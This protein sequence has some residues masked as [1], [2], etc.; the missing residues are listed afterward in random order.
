MAKRVTI[1][2]SKELLEV[3][4]FQNIQLHWN[5]EDLDITF[6]NEGYATELFLTLKCYIKDE[7]PINSFFTIKK[8]KKG[9]L[10]KEMVAPDKLKKINYEDFI[11]LMN[12]NSSYNTIG[13]DKWENFDL[14][15]GEIRFNE[16]LWVIGNYPSKLGIEIT[17]GY[18]INDWNN[19]HR[20]F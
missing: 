5:N 7:F 18:L 10:L 14:I 3:Y 12:I 11:T 13:S 19:R 16:E 8:E 15:G 2:T 17:T 1:Y 6:L 9:N 4:E 20:N